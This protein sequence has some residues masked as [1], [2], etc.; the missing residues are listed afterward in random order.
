MK[1]VHTAPPQAIL[2]DLDDTIIDLGSAEAA[3]RAVCESAAQEVDGLDAAAL[4]AAIARIREWFWSD[5]ERHRQGRADLRAASRGIVH[6]ALSSLGHDRPELATI[7]ADTYRDFRNGA[8]RVFPGAVE[9]LE[10]LRTAGIR[11]GLVTN[12]SAAAQRAKIERFNLARHFEHVLIEGEFGC[13][14]PDTRVYVAAMEA[15]RSQPDTTW[16]VGDNLEWE[17]AAPQRLGLYTVWVD[18]ARA[19]LPAE[20]AVRPDRVIHSLAE[21]VP[22]LAR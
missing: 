5:P 8:I 15:L 11:L 13:G 21:I 6:Q 9:T 22:R 18:A 3:W 12:G 2:V 16:S 20:A 4:Y 10:R 1:R 17:V 7:V 14:K 19:G